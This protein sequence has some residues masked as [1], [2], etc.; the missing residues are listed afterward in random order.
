[1]GEEVGKR[2][3]DYEILAVLGAGGMGKVYKVR[4]VISDRVEAM[5]V[6]LPDLAGR[7]ELAS[8]FLREIKILAALNHPNIAALRTA[9]TLD[10]QLVMIMEYVEG[11]TLAARLELGPI[12]P[13]EAIDCINQVLDALSYAHGQSVIHRD[14]KP[15]NMMLTPQGVVKLMDFGIA[16]SGRDPAL[17][18]AGTTMG[19]LY[20]MSP[21]QVRGEVV[22]YRSDLYSV[23]VS[24]YEMVTGQ[25]PFQSDS[26]VAIMAAHLQQTPKPP[27]EL[28]PDLPKP[29]SDIIMTAM[30]KNPA[31]RFPS[32]AAFRVALK[33]AATSAV[34]AGTVPQEGP[35]APMGPVED[36]LSSSYC[37]SAA[38]VEASPVVPTPTP[39]PTTPA[40]TTPQAQPLP[41]VL[42]LSHSQSRHRGLYMGLGALIVVA[43][44]VAAGL[45]VP[46]R[47]KASAGG[48]TGSVAKTTPANSPSTSISTSASDSIHNPQMNSGSPSQV[49]GRGATTRPVASPPGSGNP[50]S[51]VRDASVPDSNP[52][53]HDKS[54]PKTDLA[55]SRPKGSVV[56]AG[57]RDTF[58]VSPDRGRAPAMGHD[59][60]P[61]G[62]GVGTQVQSVDPK[63]LEDLER[64]IDQLASRAGA[65][66]D[67]LDGLRRQQASQG[68]SL[69]GDIA[70]A[71][72]R[73][74]NYLGKAQAA[75]QKEDA[76]ASKK[77]MELAEPEIEK[78][79]K[80]LGR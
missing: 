45:Y 18:M 75:M 12:P 9:L 4:N 28:R 79:E 29:L 8:R 10:N 70:S 16:R 50:E 60:N 5:K 14:I 3:G 49:A 13:S 52:S 19:S 27:I 72:Q 41:S 6:L 53:R 71:L 42:G 59:S 64:Q 25:R 54:S 58:S 74:D 30:T 36:T 62:S 11:K 22:D 7:Q 48:S 20:Y 77:Y 26:D 78:L 37:F 61:G 33:A 44:L 65:V 69:R 35:T 39:T 57:Q 68:L 24:L 23:G 80:F 1:M 56:P 66:H 67:S 2:V 15:S 21:E 31:E 51:P 76:T 63:E 32:A 38:P 40:P 34:V 47:S 55:Q 17:T 73:M 43:V 46:R